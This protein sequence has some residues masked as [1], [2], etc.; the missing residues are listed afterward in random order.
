MHDPARPPRPDRRRT[1]GWMLSAMGTA[2]L[3]PLAART[4]GALAGPGST[5]GGIQHALPPL[6]QGPGYG[7]DPD[8]LHDY[9]PGEPWPLTLG[10]GERAALAALC[11]LIIPA[12]DH[13]P[14]ASAVGVVDFLDEWIS[15][16]YPDQQADRGLLLPGLRALMASATAAHGGP[17]QGLDANAQLALLPASPFRTRIRQLVA[18]GFY[19]TPEG[20]RDLQFIGETPSPTYEGP[21]AAVLRAAGYA[22]PAY[23]EGESGWISLFDGR[24]LDGWQASEAPGTF[25]VAGGELVVRGPRS[26]LYYVGPVQSHEFR[27][28]EFEAEVRTRPGAN[29][30]VY[31]HTRFQQDGWPE[32][33]YEVQV[34]NSHADPSR[35]AGLYGIADNPR[36]PAADDQWFL[37]SI[38]VEGRHV[39]TRVNGRVVC[40]YTEPEGV[41]REPQYAGRLLG[42]GTFALQGHDP[43]SEIHYRNLRVRPLLVATR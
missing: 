4:A 17:F 15:A 34:N 38:R 13:S 40:D 33:G 1:I 24:T 3:A 42:S 8:L 32:R 29:S 39:Q 30:G 19:S 16:P 28:F 5:A 10:A 31:F 43:G 27:D 36:V 11:D 7:T 21:S 41:V 35:T 26:H 12:D 18:G 14:S 20:A 6:P 37:L 22:P 25:S 2:G 23:L 9:R